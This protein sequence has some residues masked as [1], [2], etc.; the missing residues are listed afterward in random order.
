MGKQNL[1]TSSQAAEYLCISRDLF[2]RYRHEGI[3]NHNSELIKSLNCV[4]K[5][6]GHPTFYFLYELKEVKEKLRVHSNRSKVLSTQEAAK[7]L[8]IT[9]ST[10]NTYRN[11]FKEK[12][13][14]LAIDIRKLNVASYIGVGNYF[15][16]NEVEKIASKNHKGF[17][18]CKHCGV[19]KLKTK[20]NQVFC[21]AKCTQ[22]FARAIAKKSISRPKFIAKPEKNSLLKQLNA[23]NRVV[24]KTYASYSEIPTEKR[25]YAGRIALSPFVS[26]CL[27]CKL[28]KCEV[29][30]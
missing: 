10:F 16:K 24:S 11:P 20:H 27:N 17:F 8:G 1:L 23:N 2:K 4:S 25:C 3:N 30:E 15:F 5:G 6:R 7:I 22:R 14:A 9:K 28:S 29:L 19:R 26:E 18:N 21:S 13:G 12:M